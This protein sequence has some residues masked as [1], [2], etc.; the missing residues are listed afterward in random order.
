MNYFHA[1]NAF[2]LRGNSGS[3]PAQFRIIFVI[4][5]VCRIRTTTL[6]NTKYLVSG[7]CHGTIPQHCHVAQLQQMY[8]N[9]NLLNKNRTGSECRGKY[10]SRQQKVTH[11][12]FVMQLHCLK[13]QDGVFHSLFDEDISQFPRTTLL[14]TLYTSCC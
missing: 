10:K 6:P 1:Q 7:V 14:H 13:I 12:K 5:V 9:C 4:A 3:D 2:S 11:Q 8:M